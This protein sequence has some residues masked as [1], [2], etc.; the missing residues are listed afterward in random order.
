MSNYALASQEQSPLVQSILD[1]YRE[2]TYENFKPKVRDAFPSVM[3]RQIRY[4]P[5]NPPSGSIFG[6]ILKYKLSNTAGRLT[7]LALKFHVEVTMG[8][9]LP[10]DTTIQLGPKLIRVAAL[11]QNSRILA[12]SDRRHIEQSLDNGDYERHTAFANIMGDGAGA[13]QATR[14]EIYVPLDFWF[15]NGLEYALDSSIVKDL[16]L[17]VEIDSKSNI[18]GAV[19][20]ITSINWFD[21]TY[22]LIAGYV[23]LDPFYDLE[24]NKK[25]YMD[26]KPLTIPAYDTFNELVEKTTVQ[27]DSE[28]V[29]LP[30]AT[31]YVKPRTNFFVKA[32]HF[33]AWNATRG[34]TCPIQSVE[35]HSSGQTIFSYTTAESVIS[36]HFSQANTNISNTCSV[37]YGLSR[38]PSVVSGGLSFENLHAA[39]FKITFE[40]DVG[41]TGDTLEVYVSHTTQKLLELEPSSGI[42]T[43]RV[44]V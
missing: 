7:Y 28:G 34:T 13:N 21:S 3:K 22:E 42:I 16:E 40:G 11:R 19:T 37:F 33:F 9:E 39:Q 38:D 30:Y 41:E 20:G 14:M 43:T 12:N 27:E 31:V 25:L 2:K 10:G 8:T 44:E 24:L 26:N 4:T 36:N 17:Q 29:Q 1:K 32:S 6:T 5:E 15:N 35:L 23:N 18:F